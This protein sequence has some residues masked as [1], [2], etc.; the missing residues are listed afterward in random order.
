LNYYQQALRGDPQNANFRAKLNQIRF[1]AG[2]AHV[3]KGLDLRK[4]GDLQGAV[5]EFQRAQ[6]VDPSSP[7]AEQELRRTLEMVEA[8]NKANQET[9]EPVDSSSLAALPPEIK[10]LSHAPINLKMANDAKLVFDTIGKLAGLTVIYDPDFP[11]RR[12]STE[13]NNVTL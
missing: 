2:E 10:P 8:A 7:V 6:T 3:K 11:A 4:K 1:E 13:L 12:I 5:N 9:E